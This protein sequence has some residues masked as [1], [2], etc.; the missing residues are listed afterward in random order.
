M[1]YTLLA[2]LLVASFGSQAQTANSGAQSAAGAQSGSA[3]NSILYVDQSV[4]STQTIHQSIHQTGDFT[5]TTNSHVSGSTTIKNVPGIAMSGPA[6]G[7]CTG[8]SGGI[9]I[10]G[11]GFGFGINGAKV[12]PSC[13]L[14]E[15]IRVTG[16]A[17]QSLDGAAHPQEKGALLVMM[18]DQMRGLALMSQQIIEEN[19][20]PKA[21]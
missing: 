9:G 8:S 13:V 19:V 1:K 14:R 10:G 20:K 7:P 15:N 11:P 4:P 5:Q 21:K 6:S 12:E 18:M 17:M 3:A 16:M 2:A